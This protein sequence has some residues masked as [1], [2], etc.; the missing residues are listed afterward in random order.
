M[1]EEIK[2]YLLNIY[3]YITI[4]VT[5]KELRKYIICVSFEYNEILE[6][7]HIEYTWDGYMSIDE[8]LTK[9]EFI[10]DDYILNSFKK[11]E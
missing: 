9:I 5:Y 7:Q 6:S 3:K 10:I 2:K 1:E 11:G 4:N 8:N